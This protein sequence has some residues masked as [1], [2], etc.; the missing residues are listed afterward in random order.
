MVLANASRRTRIFALRCCRGSTYP[1]DYSL[2]N[3]DPSK[4]GKAGDPKGEWASCLKI[5]PRYFPFPLP[6]PYSP[7][8]LNY[9]EGKCLIHIGREGTANFSKDSVKR[10]VTG[11]KVDIEFDT[12]SEKNR[13]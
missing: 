6:T 10:E 12:W 3:P 1:P 5:P 7:S 13:P 4:R 11:Q 8:T 9:W 2:P